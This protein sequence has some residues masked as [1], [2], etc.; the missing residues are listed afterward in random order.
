MSIEGRSVISVPISSLP[1]ALTKH[2]HAFI[3]T[4]SVTILAT[5]PRDD[6]NA[7]PCAATLVDFA[8][9]RGLL[10]ARHVWPR[11]QKQGVLAIVIEDQVIRIDQANLNAIV[12]PVET[13]LLLDAEVPDIAFVA[14]TAAHA[15]AIEARGRAFY[16]V[17]KR[18]AL[19]IEELGRSDGFL[20]LVGSPIERLDRDAGRVASLL[21]DTNSG[22]AETR[23]RWDYTFVNLSIESNTEI[24]EN[25]RGS[26][27]G[28]FGE[29]GTK[30]LLVVKRCGFK[31]RL[32]TSCWSESTSTKRRCRAVN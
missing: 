29:Y 22:K 24:P 1:Q 13:M 12:P 15:S 21:Y 10:T 28:D 8:G 18:R 4:R 16:S 7:L 19:G 27:A 20:V 30:C 3:R 6:R 25:L 26:V 5:E 17:G 32:L 23:D 31:I 14:L 9:K 2:A 11:I